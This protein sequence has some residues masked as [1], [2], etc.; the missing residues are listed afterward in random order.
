MIFDSVLEEI[1]RGQ[2]GLNKGLPHGLSKLSQFL[3]NVQQKTYYLIGASTGCGKTT[4]VDQMFMYEPFEYINNTPDCE[5]TLDI[6]YFSF[7]IDKITK[8]TKGVSRQLFNKYKIVADV[9]YILSRGE[10][11]VSQEI[12]DK[13]I[14]CREYFEK[15]ENSLTVFDMPE[16]PTGINKYLYRKAEKFGKVY[17][18]EVEKLDENGKTV[19]FE[20]F[21]RYEPY[22]KN[23]YHIVIIDHISLL[24]EERG[25]NTKQLIDKMSQYLVLLRNN[26]NIIPVVVQQLNYDINDPMRAKTN[27][28][29]PM[30]SDFGDSKY[31]TRDANYV[32]S[33]FSPMTFDIQNFAG[34]NVEKLKDRFRSLEILKGRDGGI[35]T[36]VGLGYLGESGVFKELPRA[37]QMTD[38]QYDGLIKLGK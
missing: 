18:K 16:N 14:E 6:D 2:E 1:K 15:L 3:P 13:V 28:L 21:D 5:F 17:R 19:K 32:L 30:L 29:T 38:L 24:P 33:L 26:F 11:R 36:R 27:R 22:D 12:Y 9:N 25:Y 23:R 35:G 4:L 8:I 31:T 37:D 7:E 34:Y 20:V 10:H